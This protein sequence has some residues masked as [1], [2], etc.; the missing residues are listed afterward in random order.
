M[1]TLELNR[2][3]EIMDKDEIDRD[4]YQILQDNHE[5]E[6]LREATKRLYDAIGE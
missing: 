6:E 1:T 4:E 5:L 2:I 3:K